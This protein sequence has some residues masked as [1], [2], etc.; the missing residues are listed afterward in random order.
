M[1][2]VSDT[3]P[4]NYLIIIGRASILPALFGE[5]VVPAAVLDELRHAKTPVAVRE[6]ANT[7]PGW[8]KIQH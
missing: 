1:I 5:V 3:S 6:F 2:V 4:L 7:P 8:V